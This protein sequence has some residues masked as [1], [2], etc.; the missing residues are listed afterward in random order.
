[1]AAVG[2]SGSAATRA[3]AFMYSKGTYAYG[4]YPDLDE[5]FE[6]AGRSMVQEYIIAETSKIY[7]LQ[8]A[9]VS[10]KHLEVVVKQMFS[11]VKITEA[12]DTDYSIGD[13]V[14]DWENA[15]PSHPELLRWLGRELVTPRGDLVMPGKDNWNAAFFCG[16]GVQVVNIAQVDH[17]PC[18]SASAPITDGITV[19]PSVKCSKL[20]R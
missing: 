2:A 4:G 14:E 7:E 9:P 20:R 3:E 1:M 19:R 5:L 16:T 12:G 8:G 15:A 17:R 6:H 10:R 13:V 11:R 18:S